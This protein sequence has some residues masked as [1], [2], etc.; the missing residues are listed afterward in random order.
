MAA[1][2]RRCCCRSSWAWEGA[3]VQ[4]QYWSWVALPDVVGS[5]RHAM[6]TESLAGPLNV[7]SP[8]PATNAEFTKALAKVLHRPAV[9]PMPAAAARLALGEMADELL[10]ASARVV[11]RKLE[12]SGYAFQ[13]RDL[14]AALRAAL[15]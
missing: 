11:P 12:S 2:C 14:E 8:R 7:V 15:T 5:I 1:R 9:F 6:A 13:F 10:L 3:S 4:G